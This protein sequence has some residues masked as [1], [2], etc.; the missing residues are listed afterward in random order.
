MEIEKNT[1]AKLKI[2]GLA[3][4]VAF[5]AVAQITVKRRREG[6]FAV[7]SRCQND[8]IINKIASRCQNDFIINKIDI[9]PSRNDFIINKIEMV[10]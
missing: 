2:P 1:S 8:F 4:G 3:L 6:S 9:P 5:T 10:N 7:A